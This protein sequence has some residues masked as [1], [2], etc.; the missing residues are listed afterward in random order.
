[1]FSS[2]LTT[3]RKHL[4]ATSGATASAGVSASSSPVPRRS[5]DS[6]DNEENAADDGIVFGAGADTGGEGGAG[7]DGDGKKNHDEPPPHYDSLLA[8]AEA[9]DEGKKVLG[10]A[11]WAK[12]T[13]AK[14]CVLLLYVGIAETRLTKDNQFGN[15]NKFIIAVLLCLKPIEV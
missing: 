15:H 6:E 14:F 8:L 9:G 2:R 5:R 7:G 3:R 4:S 11:K 10:K 1:M 13:I 12:F